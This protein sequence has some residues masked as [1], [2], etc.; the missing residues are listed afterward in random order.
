MPPG[1]PPTTATLRPAA[2]AAGRS[3]GSRASNPPSAAFNFW[4][5][6]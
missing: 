4:A 5:R 3:L 6:M 2:G 1:P